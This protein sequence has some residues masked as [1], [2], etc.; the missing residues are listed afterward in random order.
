MTISARSSE[1]RRAGHPAGR[2]IVLEGMPGA[3]KTTLAAALAED[4]ATV[5]GEY[6]TPRGATIPLHGHPGTGDGAGHD[7]NWVRKARQ[8]AA[9]LSDGLAV[10]A[11][12][13]WLSALAYAYSIA[14]IDG[15]QLL[16]QRC[17][18]VQDCLASRQLLL[19]HAY[20]IFDVAVTTSLRRRSA[21]LDSGH[22]WTIPGPLRRLRH[23]YAWPAQVIAATHPGLAAVLLEPAWHRVPATASPG[24]RMRLL[25]DLG[26]PR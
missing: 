9:A 16:R 19:P 26:T 2:L 3:G 17:E 22:P 7:A 25:S 15:G 24:A 23:F 21:R 1:P 13:D 8:A 10:Y 20:V 4:G 18:W 14:G 5:L 6:T 11:D 12:R